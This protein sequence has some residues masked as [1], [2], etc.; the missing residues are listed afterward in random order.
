MV[1]LHPPAIRLTTAQLDS[2]TGQ[3]REPNGHAIETIFRQ[4]DHL[5]ERSPDGELIG[6]EAESADSFFRPGDTTG[7]R[8]VHLTFERDAQGR[9]TAYVIDDSRHQERWAKAPGTNK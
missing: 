2:L 4:G 1:P 8:T 7:A 6:L 3:Y 5:F 9:A